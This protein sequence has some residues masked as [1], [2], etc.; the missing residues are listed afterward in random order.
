MAQ[1]SAPNQ[2]WP[3]F[4]DRH[5]EEG[6]ITQQQ[7]N[8]C[9]MLVYVQGR[10][11]PSHIPR[12]KETAATAVTHP[13]WVSTTY[14]TH[15]SRDLWAGNQAAMGFMQGYDRLATIAAQST[16]SAQWFGRTFEAQFQ[17]D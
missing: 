14:Y 5:L 15:G 11:N 8:P 17:D 7:T 12:S 2:G 13:R 3:R 9:D 16:K 10:E 4:Y 6:L 1:S